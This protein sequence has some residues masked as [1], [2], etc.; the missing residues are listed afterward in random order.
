MRDVSVRLGSSLDRA[1][2]H[3]SGKSTGTHPATHYVE[4]SL[5]RCSINRFIPAKSK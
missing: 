3:V 5:L 2:R 1:T 4:N